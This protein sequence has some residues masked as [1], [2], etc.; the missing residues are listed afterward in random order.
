MTTGWREFCLMTLDR[1]KKILQHKMI[2]KECRR[3]TRELAGLPGTAAVVL[4][5]VCGLNP[6]LNSPAYSTRA[7]G[8]PDNINL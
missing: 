1:Q 6:K 2:G 3:D 4:E 7:E 5:G 8:N